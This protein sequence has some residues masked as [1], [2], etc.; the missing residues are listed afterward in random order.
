MTEQDLD[1]LKTIFEYSEE[2]YSGIKWKINYYVGNHNSI[3]RAWEGKDAGTMGSRGYYTVQY[4]DVF[5]GSVHRLIW[6]MHNGIISSKDTID[7]INGIKTDNRISNL[8]LV[9]TAVNA[10]NCKKNIKNTSGVTGVCLQEDRYW[11]AQWYDELSKIKI[12][13]F[14][15]K[16]FGYENAFNLACKYREDKIK[17]LNDRGFLYSERHGL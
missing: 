2:S 9:S 12:K 5:S 7:H 15:I 14:S 3:L 13:Y 17:E 16:K 1:I 4:K 8:R 10:R 6:A 11:K